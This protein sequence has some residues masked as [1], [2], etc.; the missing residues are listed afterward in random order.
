MPPVDYNVTDKAAHEALPRRKNQAAKD[1]VW[2]DIMNELE[3]GNV[4]QIKYADD[5]ERGTLARSVGRRAAHR[6]F[7]VDI[8]QGD[9][10][11]SVAKADD[12]PMQQAE[13]GDD[14]GMAV[15]SM[16]VDSEPRNRRNRG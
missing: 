15:D 4:V 5:K 2:Q 7:R 6:G 8:R 10:F 14:D 12:I 11:I 16:T 1:P 13:M 9:G 3:A